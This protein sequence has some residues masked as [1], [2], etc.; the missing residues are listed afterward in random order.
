MMRLCLALALVAASAAAP[1][2]NTPVLRMRGG[3]KYYPKLPD[4]VK[5]G[6]ITGQA[7]KDLLQAAKEQGYAIPAVNCVTSSSINTVLEAGRKYNSPVMIQFSNGG[8]QFMAGKSLPND[9]DKLQACVTGAIAVRFRPDTPS[10]S[11]SE[12]FSTI[13]MFGS[14]LYA[15]TCCSML[16][17]V[18]QARNICTGREWGVSRAR[19]SC[20]FYALWCIAKAWRRKGI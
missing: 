6:V 17:D 20:G 4:S 12:W 3:G 10:T 18:G 15:E 9:K 16:L 7:V 14:V 11:V 8:S 5:P 1:V 2:I 13:H 19:L